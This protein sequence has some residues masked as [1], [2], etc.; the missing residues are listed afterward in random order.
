[1]VDKGAGSPWALWGALSNHPTVKKSTLEDLIWFDVV[2]NTF[3]CPSWWSWRSSWIRKVARPCSARGGYFKMK[4]QGRALQ[5]VTEET[6]ILMVRAAV[7]W[8]DT[9]WRRWIE[10]EW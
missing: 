1:M 10:A 7:L 9:I 2:G 4:F 5:R 8:I 6:L 3:G